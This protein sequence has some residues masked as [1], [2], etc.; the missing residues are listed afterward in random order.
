MAPRPITPRDAEFLNQSLM[1]LEKIR[2]GEGMSDSGC[3][4]R[5]IAVCAQIA[6]LLDKQGRFEQILI[7]PH[8]SYSQTTPAWG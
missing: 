2:G 6:S 1:L 8:S 7:L 5:W 4:P 3:G